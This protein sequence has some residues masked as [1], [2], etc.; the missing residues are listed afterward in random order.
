MFSGRN[1][2]WIGETMKVYSEYSGAE[3]I[4]KK[5]ARQRQK[6]KFYLPVVL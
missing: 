5:D 1:F 4:F 6:I 3:V 2:Q